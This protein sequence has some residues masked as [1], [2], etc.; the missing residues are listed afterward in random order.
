MKLAID[1]G[2]AMIRLGVENALRMI[3][4]AGFNSIDYHIKDYQLGDDYRE[5]AR[6]FK[7]LLDKYELPCVLTHAPHNL[8]YGTAMDFSNVK[9]RD[10]FR[11]IEFT[12]I[13]GAECCV[14]HCS[15]VPDGPLSGQF[16]EHNY[17]YYKSFEQEAERCGVYIGVENLK[18]EKI[19]RPEYMNKLLGM[20]DS[21]MFY[22]HVDIGHSALVG[23]DP[24]VFLKKMTHLPIRAMHVHDYN[25]QTDHMIPF[26]G[27][28][29]WDRIVKAIV[30]IGYQ[31]DL[32]MELFRTHEL[33]ESYS[34]EILPDL[35]RLIA[36]V[37]H[38]LIRRIEE[39]RKVR[40]KV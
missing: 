21:P 34:T 35:Y 24:A 16:G 33:V 37:G 38:E 22:P 30:D 40:A 12:K 13:L 26:L 2:S 36:E 9:Y 31:G 17:I 28:C 25:V 5:Q 39:E 20:L 1:F 23:T 3:K 32:S 27:E 11:S 8:V 7:A 14:I 15:S 19:H 18:K 29:N 6:E 10:N 4:E